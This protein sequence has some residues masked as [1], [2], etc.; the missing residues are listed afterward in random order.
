MKDLVGNLVFAGEE[1]RALGARI[2]IT[3]EQMIYPVYED[4]NRANGDLAVFIEPIPSPTH[5]VPAG[6]TCVIVTPDDSPETLRTKLIEAAKM[7][8]Q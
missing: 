5:H 7:C 2:R 1:L 6:C 4:N 8:A 3:N